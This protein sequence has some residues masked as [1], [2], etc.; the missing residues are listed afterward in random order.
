MT[1]PPKHGEE[2][3]SQKEIGTC[4]Q[5]K[6]KEMSRQKNNHPLWLEL[7]SHD[8][9]RAGALSQAPF[10]PPSLHPSAGHMFYY[11]CTGFIFLYLLTDLLG[12]FVYS[13][14]Q[15]AL[16][17]LPQNNPVSRCLDSNFQ[18]ETLVVLAPLV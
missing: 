14:W 10:L 12:L 18:Q 1:V 17:C 11:V 7:S 13:K 6:G 3:I 5:K 16:E 15:T 4:Y 8:P 2:V 9:G